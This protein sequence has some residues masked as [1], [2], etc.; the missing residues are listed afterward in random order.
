[1]GSTP[2]TGVTGM[3]TVFLVVEIVMLVCFRGREKHLSKISENVVFQGHSLLKNSD[4]DRLL[5]MF[6][7]EVFLG[8]KKFNF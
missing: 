6:R 1:M 7:I 2:Y 5:A 4:F 3:I 8:S